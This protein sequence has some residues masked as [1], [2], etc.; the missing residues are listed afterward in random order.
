M[1]T[2]R[3]AGSGDL[4]SE[5]VACDSLESCADSAAITADLEQA[6][7]TITGTVLLPVPDTTPPESLEFTI[8]AATLSPAGALRRAF[9]D[10]EYEL[11][12]VTITI[13]MT[14]DGR[15][16]D[17]RL[18]A[19]AT[20]KNTSPEIPGMAEFEGCLGLLEP[21]ACTGLEREP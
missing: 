19:T 10:Y 4:G 1:H 16:E 3:A 9:E 20:M 17:S 6:E 5:V 15:I 13:G 21:L 8:W 18:T 14:W 2:T 7:G 12:G 11:F